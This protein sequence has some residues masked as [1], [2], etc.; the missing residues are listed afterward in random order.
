MVVLGQ[1]A[2]D[3]GLKVDDRSEDT[4]PDALAGEFREKAFDGI[5][6]GARGWGKVKGPAG[7]P[8]KPGADFFVLMSGVVVE[9]GVDDFACGDLS[10]DGVQEADE[11][12]MAVALHVAADDGAV[13]HI[14]GGVVVPWR[15]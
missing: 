5:E 6:P 9:N 1:V 14:E 13:E 7:M 4:A 12:L 10:L 8:G 11:L 2:V 3:G 15:L